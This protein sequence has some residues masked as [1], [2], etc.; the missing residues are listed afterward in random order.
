MTDVTIRPADPD[1]DST[2]IAELWAA[3]APFLV[4]TPESIRFGMRGARPDEH[5]RHLV[6]ERDGRVVGTATAKFDVEEDA[7]G[8]GR[9][10]IMVFPEHRRQ[11]VGS[12]L[13]TAA[14]AHLAAIGARHV[15]ARAVEDYAVSFAKRRGFAVTRSERVSRLRID[16]VP[17]PVPVPDGMRFVSLAGLGDLRLAHDL[18]VATVSDIPNDLTIRALPFE[19]WR[20]RYVDDPSLDHDLTRYVLDGDTAVAVSMIDRVGARIWSQFTGV[21]RDRRGRG[22]AK[23]VKVASLR[24][25]A[26][27][28]VT[29]AYTNND[30]TN[31]GMLAVNTWLGYRLHVEQFALVRRG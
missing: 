5:A 6:A 29:E 14:D 17:E 25:A 27:R 12:A 10:T 8:A 4:R 24:A 16:A 11:G 20:A 2:A 31:A 9:L 15:T 30:A 13:C 28:G 7:D 19:E 21:R 26:E 18:E 3:C 22:L 1:G 23:A